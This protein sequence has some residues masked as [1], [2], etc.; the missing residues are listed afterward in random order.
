MKIDAHQHFWKF[1]SKRDTWITD[2]MQVIKKD[3][4][5]SDLKPL[6]DDIGID[7]CVAVQANQSEQENKFLLDL[8]NENLWI[9]GVVGWVDL[10][11]NNVEERLDFFSQN[12]KFKGVRHIL[13]AEVNGFMNS[14]KFIEGIRQLSKRRLTYD[15]LVTEEQ[16][17]ET[18]EL[19]KQLPNVPLVIDHLAKP[20]I[21]SRYF[22][23]WTKFMREISN[24]EN[25]LVKLS[26]MVTEA[27]WTEWKQNDFLPYLDFC[28]EHFGPSRLMYGSDWPVCNLAADYGT[29][30]QLLNDYVS[31]LSP[32]EQEQIMGLTAS[33]FY[34]L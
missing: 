18:V 7:G 15:L 33:N 25:V 10:L 23:R 11:N 30:Y 20:A 5:P 26:G 13:Q 9:E 2:E 6:L 4:M 24:Y 1:D 27:K 16:L 29:V 8:A 28:L 31:Q 12:R 22:D 14:P 32:S 34:N 21:K 17:L 3:F 19:I